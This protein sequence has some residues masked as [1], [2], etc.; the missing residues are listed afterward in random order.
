VPFTFYIAPIKR[1]KAVFAYEYSFSD[2]SITKK[3]PR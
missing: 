3:L 2:L 1:T